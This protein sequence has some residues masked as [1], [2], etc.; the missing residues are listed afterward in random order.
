MMTIY[1][2]K[3]RSTRH[4][5]KQLGYSLTRESHQSHQNKNYRAVKLTWVLQITGR[6]ICMQS[7]LPRIIHSFLINTQYDTYDTNS[8]RESDK[9][10]TGYVIK[11]NNI[12]KFSKPYTTVIMSKYKHYHSLGRSLHKVISKAFTFDRQLR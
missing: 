7:L 10:E 5:C 9:N 11:K 1:R 6:V 4:E 3:T 8:K 12:T 2:L